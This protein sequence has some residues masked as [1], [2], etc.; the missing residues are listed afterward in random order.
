MT[1]CWFHKDCHFDD[2]IKIFEKTIQFIVWTAMH[3][4]AEGMKQYALPWLLVAVMLG[5]VSFVSYKC[6]GPSELRHDKTNK[7]T[8]RP[9]KTRI[10]LG[11]SSLIRVFAVHSMCSYRPKLSSCGQWRLWSD[12]ADAQPDLSLHWAHSHFV[13]FVMRWLI[14]ICYLYL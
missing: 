7:M 12:W 2:Q 6:G 3:R 10:S 9:E 14:F 5:K 13:G 8:V 4:F 11:G 1:P